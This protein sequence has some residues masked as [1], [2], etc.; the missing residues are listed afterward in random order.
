MV[1]SLQREKKKN[2]R[3][4]FAFNLNRFD[5]INKSSQKPQE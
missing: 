3:L 5:L 1:L 4:R 2:W